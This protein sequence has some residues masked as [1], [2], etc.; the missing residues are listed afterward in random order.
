MSIRSTPINSQRSDQPHHIPSS[1][2]IKNDSTTRTYSASHTPNTL[3]I[4]G[5]Q[6]PTPHSYISSDGSYHGISLTNDDMHTISRNNWLTD[7]VISFYYQYLKYEVFGKHTDV[8]LIKPT[9]SYMLTLLSE[10]NDFKQSALSLRLHTRQI[11]FCPLNNESH[12]AIL[13][14]VR[15]LGRWFYY[16]SIQSLLQQQAEVLCAR[17]YRLTS[18]SNPSLQNIT[19]DEWRPSFMSMQTPQQNNSYDCGMYVLAITHLL[20]DRYF[21]KHTLP[22]SI[23]LISSRSMSRSRSSSPAPRKSI[24]KSSSNGVINSITNVFKSEKTIQKEA[25]ARQLALDRAEQQARLDEQ[26]LLDEQQII[27]ESLAEAELQPVK[28]VEP[29]HC[30]RLKPGEMNINHD[31]SD[32]FIHTFR[33]FVGMIAY[34]RRPINMNNDN[35]ISTPRSTTSSSDASVDPI[36]LNLNESNKLNGSAVISSQLPPNIPRTPSEKSIHQSTVAPPLPD[37]SPPTTPVS[38][39]N[40]ID[41]TIASATAGMKIN[42]TDH[43]ATQPPSVPLQNQSLTPNTQQQTQDQPPPPPTKIPIT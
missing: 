18:D 26:L 21:D 1:H 4:P 28:C 36:S 27:E 34:D 32:E 25:A 6:T 13:V 7:N 20:L 22:V 12:W 17:L 11:V 33:K 30:G 31:L 3:S 37:P 41:Y 24:R 14:Y 43:T 9:V 38:N 42:N 16:D 5:V 15:M 8:L 10:I 23:Q 40:D 2:V 35:M 39:S 29:K 19:D